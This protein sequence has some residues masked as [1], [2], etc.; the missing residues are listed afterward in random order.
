MLLT[1]V[2]N[3]TAHETYGEEVS[4]LDHALQAFAASF[5]RELAGEGDAAAVAAFW[6]DIGHSAG[7]DVTVRMRGPSGEDLGALDHETRGAAMMSG[8]IPPR[9]CTAIALHTQ[10]KRYMAGRSGQTLSAASSATLQ[11]QGGSMSL[12]EQLVFEGHSCMME[13]MTLRVA[14][15]A[16]KDP[17]FDYSVW[18]GRA[19]LLLLAIQQTLRCALII[20]DY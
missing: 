14:D 4:H 12:E 7:H 10:A 15:D 3:N 8:I 6:H 20:L 1:Y 18:G 17:N 2:L 16:G 5:D 13:A 19:E 11:E 9:F